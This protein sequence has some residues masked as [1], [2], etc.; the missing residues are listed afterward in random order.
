MHILV[1][2]TRHCH[3]EIFPTW[4]KLL[5][6]NKL[7][8]WQSSKS[9]KLDI[10]PF[11]S[12]ESTPQ[13][14]S[15]FFPPLSLAS[16]LKKIHRLAPDLI[17]LNSAEVDSKSKHD[18]LSL[19]Q[20]TS[21]PILALCHRKETYEEV[22][23]LNE[24]HISA[25]TLCARLSSPEHSISAVHYTEKTPPPL[26]LEDG[27]K[28]IV[29]GSVAW[30]RRYYPHLKKIDRLLKGKDSIKI[31]GSCPSR[32]KDE[33]DSLLDSTD[34]IKHISNAK[35]FPPFLAAIQQ[36]H[37]ILPLIE[38]EMP[39][40]EEY[41]ESLL[42]GTVNLS[43]GLNRP[44]L[45]HAEFLQS[46]PNVRGM[47]IGYNSDTLADSIELLRDSYLDLSKQLTILRYESLTKSRLTLLSII[48][49]IR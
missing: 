25:V 4:A 11:I 6:G 34:R 18:V 48:D 49:S 17:I 21:I 16:H 26:S 39:R 32:F 42:S 24:P 44:M 47:S 22:I 35:P 41:R 5:E 3:T 36:S 1:L 29:P 15:S 45:A 37:T 30:D 7:T 20:A 23:R 31:L 14:I 38:P 27:L 13:H 2:E 9:S 10:L 43:I 8:F 12:E 19:H 40:F 46:T 28:L 33:L